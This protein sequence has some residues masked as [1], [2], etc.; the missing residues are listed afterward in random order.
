[1]TLATVKRD[2]VKMRDE[3]L[4]LHVKAVLNI[5]VNRLYTGPERVT[6]EWI[7][8]MLRDEGN[9]AACQGCDDLGDQ[10]TDMG[11]AVQDLWIDY[12]G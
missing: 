9:R 6:L 11:L 4:D 5:A 8:L 2:M 7:A 1:M 3:V 12:L 10:L